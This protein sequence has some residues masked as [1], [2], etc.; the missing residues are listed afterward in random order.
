M[1]NLFKALA[2]FQQEV[3]II[4]KG[5]SGYLKNICNNCIYPNNYI[6]L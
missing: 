3:P 4:H 5:T 2:D 6:P 1:K